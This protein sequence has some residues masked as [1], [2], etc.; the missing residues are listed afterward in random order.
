MVAYSA[1]STTNL[2]V[3]TASVAG[4]SEGAKKLQGNRFSYINSLTT[5]GA[6]NYQA[7]FTIMSGSTYNNY[8]S[9]T[10]INI[11]SM[12]G[13]VKHTSPVIYYLIKNGSL[14]GNPNFSAYS[15]SSCS[16]VDTSAT[17]VTF[18]DNRQLQWSGHLGDTGDMVYSFNEGGMEEMTLQPGEW[19]TLA[20]RAVTGT[21]SYVTGSINTR[22]DQ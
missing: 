10:V 21:P 2:I 17:T 13:A 16:L 11:L 14:A 4:F 5:V 22:E 15:S 6:T 12:A 19:I 8:T 18:T 20:A 9:Q 7:L 3:S 1:G